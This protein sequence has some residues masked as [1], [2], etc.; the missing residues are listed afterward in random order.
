MDLG[1]FPHQLSFENQ[2]T[3]PYG[4]LPKYKGR[5]E[6]DPDTKKSFCNGMIVGAQHFVE[7]TMATVTMKH[8]Y[9]L[10]I[11]A[12]TF[13]TWKS[14]IKVLISWHEGCKHGGGFSW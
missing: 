2:N 12:L 3:K 10:M 1:I 6:V 9:Q 13:R 4:P 5:C 8:L 11:F 14:I 7:A